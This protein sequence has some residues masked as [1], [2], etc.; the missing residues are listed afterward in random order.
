M[1]PS[2]APAPGAA[3]DPPD[4]PWPVRAT[5]VRQ[6]AYCPR[7]VYYTTVVPVPRAVTFKMEY[8]TEAQA[9]VEA[10]EVRRKLRR[11]RLDAGER[12]FRV[13]LESGRLGLSG[14]I[15]LLI[16]TPEEAVPVEFKH[17]ERPVGKNH[18]AQVAVYALLA[19]EHTGLPARRGFICRLPSGRLQQ[20]ACDADERRQAL[21]IAAQ[22]RAMITQESRPHPTGVRARCTDCEFRRYCAD[23]E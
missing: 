11:Y 3:P 22:V 19:E 12:H 20:V 8:G 2:Q 5:D 14:E 1:T 23:V 6:W 13:R 15:D 10:L 17:T 4:A 18:R 9:A 21:E 16:T 7:V